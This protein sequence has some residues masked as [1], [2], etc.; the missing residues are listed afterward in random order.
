[1]DKW[2]IDPLNGKRYNIL[3]NRGLSLIQKYR[4]QLGGVACS[5]L[6]KK[7]NKYSRPCDEHGECEWIIGVGCRKCN[8]K[9]NKKSS[10][11][12][13]SHAVKK[14]RTEKSNKCQGL[15]K[16]DDECDNTTGCKWVVRE[17]CL[18][19]SKSKSKSKTT[20]KSK[21]KP[22]LKKP[23]SPRSPKSPKIKKPKSPYK[24]DAD[25]QK[26]LS[27]RTYYDDGGQYGDVVDIRYP[28]GDYKCLTKTTR[29]K[30]GAEIPRWAKKNNN[31]VDQCKW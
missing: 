29:K 26:R 21:S 23:R 3:S 7:G 31:N 2:I 25:G 1:M 18:P 20:H 27:A 28:H 11:K 15:L 12:T 6:T 9:N 19:K 30:D 4:E 24:K 5:G 8:L 16:K 10:K 17:G 14:P 13:K 22:K